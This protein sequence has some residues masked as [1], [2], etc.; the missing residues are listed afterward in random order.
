M[1]KTSVVRLTEAER[2]FL[3]DEIAAGVAPARQLAHARILLKVDAGP[4]GPAWPDAAVAEALE[5]SVATVARVRKRA[6]GEGLDAA[7]TR[8]R[9]RATPG[10]K[11]DGAQEAHLIALA[12]SAPPVGRERWTLRL[13]AERFV[14]LEVGE[15]I[16]RETVRRTLK[17]TSS[18]RG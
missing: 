10:R 7:L 2:A 4:H 5:V 8:R 18:S 6:V 16:S 14:T 17:K 1:R 11:L 13:L 3:R 9:P 12:C 15:P